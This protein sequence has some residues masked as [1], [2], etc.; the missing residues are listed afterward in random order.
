LYLRDIL[1]NEGSAVDAAIA[2][3]IC[4]GISNPQSMGIGGGHMMIIYFRY[5]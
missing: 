3:S 2:V 1:S 5:K 4:N